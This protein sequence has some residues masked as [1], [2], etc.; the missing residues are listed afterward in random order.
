MSKARYILG[1]DTAMSGCSASLYDIAHDRFSSEIRPMP[2]GQAEFLVPMIQEAVADAGVGFADIDAIATTIGPGAFTGLRIGLST[3]RTMGLALSKPVIGC[4]TTD[5]LAYQFFAKDNIPQ[6]AQLIV[7]L[8]TKRKDFYIQPYD[9]NGAALAD[10]DAF[11]LD[12]VLEVAAARP[13]VFIGDA[14][15]RFKGLLAD[16]QGEGFTYIEG[17]DQP[18][19]EVICSLASDYLEKG[20]ASEYPAEPLYLR[21]ADT[22]KPKKNQRILAQ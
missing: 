12:D 9:E 14:L 16:G 18:D 1:F 22:S 5:V 13:A 7:L 11:E 8:E 21:G 6:G 15:G 19:P 3:A 10:A 20:I 17:Y 4:T 2:R